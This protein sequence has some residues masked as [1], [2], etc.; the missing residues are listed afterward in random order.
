MS[1]ILSHHFF[2]PAKISKTAQKA[3]TFL[4]I[5]SLGFATAAVVAQRLGTKNNDPL[6]VI[7]DIQDEKEETKI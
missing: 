1:K 7:L 3:L 2:S 4:T 6:P 5:V